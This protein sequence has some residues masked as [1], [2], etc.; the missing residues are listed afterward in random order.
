MKRSLF[1]LLLFPALS[2]S[3]LLNGGMENY[4][5]G[6]DTIPQDWSVDSYWSTR[7]GQSTDAHGGN[8]SFAINT[9]YNYSP[10]MMV[11]GTAPSPSLLF[12]WVL[13]G[14][15]ISYK[16][17]RL[18]GFYKYTD[19]VPGDSAIVKVLLKKWNASLNKID[20]LA[21]GTKKLSFAGS[22][23]QFDLDINDLAPGINPDSLVIFFMTF[24]YLAGIQGPCNASDCRF[25]YLDDLSLEGVLSAAETEPGDPIRFTYAD[26]EISITNLSGSKFTIEV[27]S[28]DGKR[29]VQQEFSSGQA[30][31]SLDGFSNGIYFVRCTGK[32]QKTFRLARLD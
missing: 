28:P 19:T 30:K 16:P 1:I 3:Q 11:N 14:T 13:A 2:F 27:F 25:L 32:T 22:W 26:N 12:D 9:W 10:G 17:A 6:S 21:F 4:A 5:F 23:T 7:V 29:V 18:S 20:S 24:D 15:P 8:F 31:I